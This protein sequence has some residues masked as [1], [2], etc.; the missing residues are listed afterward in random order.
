L[1]EKGEA[2]KFPFEKK[3]CGTRLLLS[4]R[5]KNSLGGPAGH[6]KTL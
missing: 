3:R 6:L 4:A 1:I 5:E 2:G